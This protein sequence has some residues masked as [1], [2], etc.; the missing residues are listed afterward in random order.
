MPRHINIS[1]FI[2]FDAECEDATGRIF[3][4]KRCRYALFIY[5]RD[6]QFIVSFA[7]FITFLT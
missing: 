1:Y 6:D 4:G 3:I 7:W 5:F 2:Y